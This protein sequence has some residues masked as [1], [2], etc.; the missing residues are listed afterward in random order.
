MVY[1]SHEDLFC[2]V[3]LGYS[4]HLFLIFS[5]SVRFIPFLSFIVPIFAWNVSLVS[6]I[7]LMRSLLLLLLLNHFSCVRLCATPWTV[8]YQAPLSMGFSRQEYS[9]VGCHF[10]LQCIKVKS[11]SEVTQS[12]PTLHDPMDCSPPGST[13]HGI[14]Q[15]RVLEWGVI[16]FST[17]I[18][19]GYKSSQS[20][21]PGLPCTNDQGNLVPNFINLGVFTICM[22]PLDCFL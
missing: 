10:P 8:S 12:Y 16:A 9:K 4:C 11:E 17:M 5:A 21:S 2:I 6:L 15:A 1:L 20:P 3:L 19:I 18:L 14:F 7:F 13:V 22:F